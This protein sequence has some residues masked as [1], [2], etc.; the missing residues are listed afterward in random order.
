[1][2]SSR[3]RSAL[4]LVH[5]ETVIRAII[6]ARVESMMMFYLSAQKLAHFIFSFVLLRKRGA[7]PRE[8][9]GREKL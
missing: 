5:V 7:N 1:M 4:S 9:P 3:E 2:V 8:S 6:A